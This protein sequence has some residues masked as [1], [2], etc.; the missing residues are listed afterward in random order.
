VEGRV[1][2]YRFSVHFITSI[3][4]AQENKE[5]NVNLEAPGK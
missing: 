3:S 4:T 1:A 5:K 2:S